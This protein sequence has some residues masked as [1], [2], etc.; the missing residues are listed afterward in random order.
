MYKRQLEHLETAENNDLSLSVSSTVND[1][2]ASISGY[3][4]MVGE[5]DDDEEIIVNDDLG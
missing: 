5:D 2:L 1:N 3:V 4:P